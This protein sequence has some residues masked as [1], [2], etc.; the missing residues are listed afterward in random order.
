LLSFAFITCGFAEPLEHLTKR[1]IANAAKDAVVK[2]VNL[3]GVFS[4]LILFFIAL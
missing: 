1:I 3:A 2:P 4:A